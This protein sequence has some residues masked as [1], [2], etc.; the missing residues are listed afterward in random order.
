[1]AS[2]GQERVLVNT[3]A[4][5]WRGW[6]HLTSLAQS[7]REHISEHHSGNEYGKIIVVAGTKLILSRELFLSSKTN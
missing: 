3:P 6:G 7:S 4:M 5:K 2:R 1:M